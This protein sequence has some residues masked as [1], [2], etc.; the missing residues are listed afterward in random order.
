M[1]SRVTNGG[2]G[3]TTAVVGC[4]F[5]R[6]LLLLACRRGGRSDSS[7]SFGEWMPLHGDLAIQHHSDAAASSAHSTHS[8]LNRN[9]TVAQH[10]YIH[11]AAES[12]RHEKFRNWLAERACRPAIHRLCCPS[13]PLCCSRVLLEP[14]R[15]IC[16][17]W[18]PLC[19]FLATERSQDFSPT[20]TLA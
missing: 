18:E 7:L 3:E 4:I 14:L 9:C 13:D 17:E 8:D 16:H 10:M 1:T 20:S 2:R 12:G 19:E 6:A 15:L 5:G 11:P